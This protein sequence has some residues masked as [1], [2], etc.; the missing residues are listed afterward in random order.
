MFVSQSLIFTVS[1]LIIYKFWSL[2]K[3]YSA[4]LRVLYKTL[5]WVCRGFQLH[6]VSQRVHFQNITT[7][8]S[9]KGNQKFIIPFLKDSNSQVVFLY[10]KHKLLYCPKQPSFL[11]HFAHMIDVSHFGMQLFTLLSA[12]N[13]LRSGVIFVYFMFLY[14]QLWETPGNIKAENCNTIKQIQLAGMFVYKP[15]LLGTLKQILFVSNSTPLIK[16]KWMDFRK[17]QP[18]WRVDK[19]KVNWTENMWPSLAL[20]QVIHHVGYFCTSI[21]FI[22]FF[23][24]WLW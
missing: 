8:L 19:V 2:K 22:P 10:T 7:P 20:I 18:Q 12:H 13:A 6:N 23:T 9:R 11:C 1:F 5:C 24:N 14:V 4:A 16:C 15:L 21:S 3:L 17:C